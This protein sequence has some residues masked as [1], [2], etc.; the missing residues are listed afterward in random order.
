MAQKHKRVTVEGFVPTSNPD[1]AHWSRER[2]KSSAA[3]PHTPTPRKGT[4]RQRERQAI[5][6]Q[7]R[8][9]A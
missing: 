6:D 9:S 8:D 4:R 5:R 3:Q 2:G 7:R 1:Q